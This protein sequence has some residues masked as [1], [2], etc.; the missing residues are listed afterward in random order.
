M[1]REFVVGMVPLALL[2]TATLG[3]ILAGIVTPT[4]AAAMGASGALLL[5]I[6]YR[7]FTFAG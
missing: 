4:E 6:A 7:R 2:I 5:S 1:V 3:T